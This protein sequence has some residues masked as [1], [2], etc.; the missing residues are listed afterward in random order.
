[1]S[2]DIKFYKEN[3]NNSGNKIIIGLVVAII[4]VGIWGLS[5]GFSKKTSETNLRSSV[6]EATETQSV[7]QPIKVVVDY[8]DLQKTETEL[9]PK[10]GMTAFSAL[11]EASKKDNVE[12]ASTQYDF[13]VMVNS[14]GAYKGGDDGKYWMYYVNSKVPEVGADQYNVGPG[15]VVEWKFEKAQ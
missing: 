13:G 15:D 11:E 7:E 14:I 12:V 10:D 2:Q 1:M 4:L 3:K 9:Q 5:K 6:S 8:G